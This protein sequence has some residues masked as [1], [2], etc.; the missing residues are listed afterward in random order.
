MN[1]AASLLCTVYCCVDIWPR[2]LCQLKMWGKGG[3]A[4]GGIPPFAFPPFPSLLSLLLSSPLPFHP[5]P[6]LFLSFPSLTLLPSITY[7]FRSL[8]SGYRGLEDRCGLPQR[9]PEPAP[10]ANAFWHIYAVVVY[11]QCRWLCAKCFYT[12]L[13]FNC[14]KYLGWGGSGPPNSPGP[15][16]T[17]PVHLA[18][19]RSWEGH[20]SVCMEFISLRVPGE[21]TFDWWTDHTRTIHTCRYQRRPS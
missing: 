3:K 10:A 4:K 19:Q 1:I 16:E 20:V 17:T 11:V 14:W 9:G 15:V 5:L 8:K 13:F 18:I 7:T 12:R 21:L 6:F 2:A